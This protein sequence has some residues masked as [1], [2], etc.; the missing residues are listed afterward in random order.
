MI[1]YDIVIFYY[2]RRQRIIRYPL[3]SLEVASQEIIYWGRTFI[4][5]CTISRL[6]TVHIILPAA[7]PIL[8]DLPRAAH[9]VPRKWTSCHKLSN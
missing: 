6:L 5:V 1:P 7:G 9:L 2:Y 4:V 3:K 8:T